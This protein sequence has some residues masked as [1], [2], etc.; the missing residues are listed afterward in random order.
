MLE[1]IMLRGIPASGKSTWAKEMIAAHPGKYKRTNKDEMRAMLDNGHW[2]KSSERFVES[3]RNEIILRC[4]NQ[5]I[6]VIVDDT[7]ISP[8]HEKTLRELVNNFCEHSEE[9]VN[10]IIKD[11]LVDPK[12]CIRRDRERAHPVGESII[13]KM[14]GDWKRNI[15]E[16]GSSTYIPKAQEQYPWLEQHI[17]DLPKT[18]IFDVDGTLALL[19]GRNPY[20]ASTCEQD[21]CNYPVFA[22]TELIANINAESHN[23]DYDIFILSGREDTYKS[24]TEKWLEKHEISYDHLLMRKTADSRSDDI[25]KRE[26][27]EEHIKG[28]YSVIGVFDDRPKVRRMWIKE[29]LFVFSCLQDPNFVDF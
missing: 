28:K 27:Y 3:L 15:G 21:L 5:G 16:Y 22:I 17:A 9:G 10:F 4:L 1:L 13:F 12:E 14:L 6:S 29:G 18:F 25:V 19:N 11:F 26:L 7:N 23:K 8:K 24:K 20:D 2:S